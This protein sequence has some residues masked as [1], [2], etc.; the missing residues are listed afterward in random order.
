MAILRY[1]TGLMIALFVVSGPSGYAQEFSTKDGKPDVSFET[2]KHDFGEIP[3]GEPAAYS[4]RIT[5]TG[6]AP[7][8]IK[9]VRPSCGCTTPKWPRKPIAPGKTAKIKAVYDAKSTGAFQKSIMVDTNVPF[10]ETQTLKIKG[11][12]NRTEQEG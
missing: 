7:L 9:D 11:V 3:Q 8:V 2:V 4:F 6:D 10:S 1:F 12:V 5:N